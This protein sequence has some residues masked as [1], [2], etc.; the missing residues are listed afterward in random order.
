MTQRILITGAAGYIGKMLLR[1]LGRN[2]PVYGLDIRDDLTHNPPI[3]AGDIRDPELHTLLKSLE[4]THVVHLASVLESS[5]DPARD[6][7]IDVN[8]TRNVIEA[9]IRADVQHVT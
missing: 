8:G 6:Y 9:C 3:H 2:H 1:K 5:G 4:I 7:D